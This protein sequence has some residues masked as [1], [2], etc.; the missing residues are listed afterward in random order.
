MRKTARPRAAREPRS[1]PGSSPN[2]DVREILAAL[3][4]KASKKVRQEALTK[5]GITAP[6][7]FG[8]PVG[9]IRAIAKPYGRDHELAL[10]LWK[11]GWY[12]ARMACAFLGDPARISPAEMDRWMREFD[13][14]AIA[15]TLC[16]HLFDRTPHAWNKVAAWSQQRGEQQK[17][18]AF[19]LLASLALHD[20]SSPDAPFRKCLPLIERAASD[21]R[22]FVKKAVSW[23]LRGVGGRSAALHAKSVALARRLADSDQPAA[24]WVGKDVLRDLSRPLVRKRLAKRA[25]KR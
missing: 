20:R 21:E 8:V 19:A 12:E 10:A 5:Y 14:W 23:A 18:A 2:S 4:R 6:K 17:R 9:T 16:F 22:N 7:A 3:E 24:R 13:N 25:S 11:T 15:D 1:R